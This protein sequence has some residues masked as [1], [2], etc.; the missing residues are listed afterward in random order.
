MIIQ[1][2]QVIEM[3]LEVQYCQ[4]TILPL[5]H[6]PR[7]ILLRLN[8]KIQEQNIHKSVF[9]LKQYTIFVCLLN[10]SRIT[11]GGQGYFRD[12]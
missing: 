3:V 12:P 6:V 2:D 1:S 8:Y 5:L 4:Y 10:F 9:V 7:P 11:G